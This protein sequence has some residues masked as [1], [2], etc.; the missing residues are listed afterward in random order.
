MKITMKTLSY[1]NHRQIKT[2]RMKVD[3]LIS[4]FFCFVLLFKP[5]KSY[6]TSTNVPEPTVPTKKN[7]TSINDSNIIQARNILE[8][9]KV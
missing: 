2:T 9:E 4:L 6:Y 5:P 1:L 7:C 8:M 3:F